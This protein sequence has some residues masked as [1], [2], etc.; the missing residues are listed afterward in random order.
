MS[1]KYFTQQQGGSF[2][3]FLWTSDVKVKVLLMI[4]LFFALT[5]SQF[6]TTWSTRRFTSPFQRDYLW[7][8]LNAACWTS[9]WN[10]VELKLCVCC[11]SVMLWECSLCKHGACCFHISPGKKLISIFITLFDIINFIFDICIGVCVCVSDWCALCFIS[12]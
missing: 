12:A 7:S 2:V 9:T 11:E 10:E 6:W 4:F 3:G 1:F 8:V 5:K